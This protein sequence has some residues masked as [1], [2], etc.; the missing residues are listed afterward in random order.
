MIK[1]LQKNHENIP[2]LYN[3]VMLTGREADALLASP[4]L[5]NWAD[6]VQPVFCSLSWVEH[7]TLLEGKLGNEM[8][9]HFTVY[10]FDADIF[11]YMH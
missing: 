2:L 10:R 1:W 7:H 6:E 3:R 4:Y 8:N 11:P 5:E 9:K